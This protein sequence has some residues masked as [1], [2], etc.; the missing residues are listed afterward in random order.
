[1]ATILPDILGLAQHIKTVISNAAFYRPACPYCGIVGMWAHGFYYRKTDRDRSSE[2]LLNPIPI[3]R[4]FCPHCEKT[5]SVLPE[6]IAPRR[7][8]LWEVQQAVFLQALLGKSLRAI[9]LLTSIS[10]STCRRWWRW[11]QEKFLLHGSVLRSYYP[12]IGRHAEFGSFWLACLKK[13]TLSKAML[14]CNQS[15]VIVP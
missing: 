8:Y 9:N 1:M 5:T 3:P 14:L 12:D 11:F 10:R 7:W 2:H 4:F 6:C 13:I 15:G